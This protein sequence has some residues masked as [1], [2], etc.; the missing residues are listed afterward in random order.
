MMDPQFECRGGTSEWI[1]CTD[2]AVFGDTVRKR[3]RLSQA[4]TI[5]AFSES[6]VDALER[7]LSL[8]SHEAEDIGDVRD[9]TGVA[10]VQRA[11]NAQHQCARVAN[12]R[13]PRQGVL[14]DSWC[15]WRP[16]TQTALWVLGQMTIRSCGPKPMR[17][18]LCEFNV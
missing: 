18:L 9:C 5:V 14:V 11:V 3:L 17:T 15:L 6:V 7:D 16:R 2:Q 12:L 10:V 4:S 1:V 13:R 8:F